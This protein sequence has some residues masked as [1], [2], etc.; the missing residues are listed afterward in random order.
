MPFKKLQF[1]PGINADATSY[2]SEG[3]WRDGDKIRFRSGFPEKI[4]G[5]ER[6]ANNYAINGVPRRLLTWR[7]LDGTLYTA[8][9]TH[10]RVYYVQGGTLVDITPIRLQIVIVNPFT[11]VSGSSVVTVAHSTHEA[12]AGDRVTISG[13]SAVGGVPASELNAEH[14]IVS[15]TSNTYTISVATNASSA[16]TSG[17]STTFVY[18]VNVGAI[19]QT[20][21]YGFGAGAWGGA[22]RAWGAAATTS[23]VSLSP[24]VWSISSWGEDLVLSPSGGRVYHWDASNPTTRPTAIT[25]APSKV[26]H[27]VVTKDRHLITFGCNTPGT[28][29]SALDTLQIRWCDQED[30][31]TWDATALT[32]AGSIRLATGTEIQG[33]AVTDSKTLVWTD[34]DVHTV[35]FTGTP[36]TF[37]VDRAGV[38]AGIIA[39]YAWAV[40]DSTLYWMGPQSF[41][42]FGSGVRPVP[43]TLHRFVYDGMSAANKLK[44]FTA[45]DRINHE[46]TWFYPT[47]VVEATAL[48][49]ELTL[50][51]TTVQVATTAGFPD[52]GALLIESES[53]EYTS[54]ND[55]EFLSCTRAASGTTAVVHADKVTVDPVGAPIPTEP[56]R[57]VT[58]NTQDGVWS[59]GRLERSAWEDSI[60]RSNPLACSPQSILYVHNLGDDA[61]GNP[62]IAFIESSDFDL[63]LGDNV[64][65]VRRFIPDLNINSGS[66]DITM[67][68]RNFPH[69]KKTAN[70]LG[71]V[72]S[73]TEK[74]DTR[75][76][77]RQASLKV[78]STDLGDS[79]E[80]GVSRIDVQPDGRR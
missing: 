39:P 50:A 29:S 44:I 69:G 43:S 40:T 60:G 24:R 26:N 42:S 72:T 75:V 22:A 34:I 47:A 18:D 32:T 61:D 31:N 80:M 4:K 20:M 33:A 23:T 59:A 79:W 37:S 58:M 49:G 3:S 41:H 54:K 52:S 67:S 38:S 68:V 71:V 62:L 45:V 16:T 19:D 63:D 14:T 30:F 65:F 77:G 55:T 48:S 5:W 11:T 66:V 78:E 10:S 36:Y 57:Y 8:V 13:S 64:S 25:N 56:C 2:A 74:L 51:G 7:D 73:S 70:L 6:D 27:F 15:V 28:S 1:T 76:R 35:K 9:C 53:I 12:L 46:I 17:G 21:Q